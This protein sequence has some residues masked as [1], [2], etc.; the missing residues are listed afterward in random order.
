MLTGQPLTTI[1]FMIYL[2]SIAAF[3]FWSANAS[4]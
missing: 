4:S 2:P 1:S 3:T